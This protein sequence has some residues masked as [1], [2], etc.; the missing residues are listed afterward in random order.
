MLLLHN[1]YQTE[2]TYRWV[3]PLCLWERLGWQS[4][5]PWR[6]HRL[7]D[8]RHSACHVGFLFEFPLSISFIGLA[9]VLF[10]VLFSVDIV[11]CHYSRNFPKVLQDLLS[12]VY[13][14]WWELQSGT[15]LN[16]WMILIP[17][18]GGFVAQ[19][20]TV[21]IIGVEM[22]DTAIRSIKNSK[23]LLKLTLK[24]WDLLL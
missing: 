10:V 12:R 19:E 13:T 14:I 17:G 11:W 8:A 1:S 15:I 4:V 21:V 7:E 16:G 24:D 20:H 2:A 18:L 6:V 23:K 3:A 9:N 22:I 5:G